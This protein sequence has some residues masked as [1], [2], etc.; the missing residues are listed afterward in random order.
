VNFFER[1]FDKMLVSFFL[2]LVMIV[3]VVFALKQP[4]GEPFKWAV[5]AFGLFFGLF[6]GLI[7]GFYMGKQA[8]ASQPQASDLQNPNE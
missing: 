2:L 5:S 6:S 7:T 4:A 8:A 3:C 1:H